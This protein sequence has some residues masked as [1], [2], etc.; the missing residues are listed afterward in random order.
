MSCYVVVSISHERAYNCN[1]NRTLVAECEMGDL[2]RQ[3]VLKACSQ[4]V[5]HLLETYSTD[6]IIAKSDNVWLASSIRY[7]YHHSGFSLNSAWKHSNFHMYTTNML[8]IES[9]WRYCCNIFGTKSIHTRVPTKLCRPKLAYHFKPW[10]A[11][12]EHHASRIS[13]T[14]ILNSCK[15]LYNRESNGPWGSNNNL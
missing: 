8:S 3:R 4:V 14:F 9:W 6:H 10:K 12:K 7:T 2:C 1:V 5:S 15:K 11:S 13:P